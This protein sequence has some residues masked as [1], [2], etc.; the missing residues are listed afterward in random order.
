[1]KRNKKY[2]KHKA[3]TIAIR[4]IDIIYAPVQKYVYT[5]K[6]GKEFQPLQSEV[7]AMERWQG[8]ISVMLG[9]LMRDQLMREYAVVEQLVICNARHDEITELLAER[10][11]SLTR[12]TAHDIMPFWVARMSD[13]TI[14]E[15]KV[16]AF[17]RTKGAYYDYLAKWELDRLQKGDLNACK[18]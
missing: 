14:S 8:K 6:F 2:N 18:K 9:F 11:K 15:E 13:I 4:N 3:T 16:I 10:Q 5:L 17:L 7:D 12:N 1:M